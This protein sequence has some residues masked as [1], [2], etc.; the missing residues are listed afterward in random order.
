MAL[1]DLGANI[2]NIADRMG[3]VFFK[4]DPGEVG[5]D[6][7]EAG[8]V[9][10]VSVTLEPIEGSPD[11][12]GRTRAATY[13][14]NGTFILMQ[15]D[16]TTLANLGVLNDPGC[17]AGATGWSDGA[18]IVITDA[19][20]SEAAMNTPT[21]TAWTWKEWE[22]ENVI[23]RTSPTLNFDAGEESF[24]EC[25]FTGRITSANLGN[26]G[27]T[28]TARGTDATTYTITF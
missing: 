3:K 22:F 17:V 8:S 7:I 14:V 19:P 2:C 26:F 24:I 23:L 16:A 12:R 13:N 1:T 25:T 5:E 11:T 4:D 15:T 27:G 9:R 10:G 18:H 28:G 20:V 6:Y 21:G